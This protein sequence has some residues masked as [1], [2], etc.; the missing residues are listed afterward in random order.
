MH[1]L[2]IRHG[3][4]DWNTE[5]RVQGHTDTALNARGLEQA[6]RLAARFAAEEAPFAALYASPQQRARVTAEIIAQRMGVAITLD[7]RLKE[8]HLGEMEGLTIPEVQTRYPEWY[9]AW[10]ESEY[11]VM[12]PGEETPIEH[13][14]RVRAFLDDVRTRHDQD[15]RVGVVS[16]GATL[17][18]LVGTVMGLDVAKRFPFWFDNASVSW[19]D[20]SRARPRVRLLND[21]CHLRDGHHK[22]E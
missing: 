21:L 1:L 15:E 10:R 9:Q 5:M 22:S 18:M 3:E 13:Q 8:K 11:H 17:I 14:T 20:W 2:L 12:M 7:E 6:E 4:T 16:H 19:I